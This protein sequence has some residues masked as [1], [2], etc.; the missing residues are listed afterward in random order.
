MSKIVSEDG[1]ARDRYYRL[2]QSA[3]AGAIRDV[4]NQHGEVLSGS[5]GK[6]VA[7]QIRGFMRPE[8]HEDRESWRS[9]LLALV[10]PEGVAELIRAQVPT[11]RP[12]E[13]A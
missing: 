1:A 12:Q 2:V 4:T 7:A 9:F 5:V 10:G 3:V 13:G 11:D 8:A 6:R